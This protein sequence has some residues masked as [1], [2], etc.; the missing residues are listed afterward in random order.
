M[1][2]FTGIFALCAEAQD[3]DVPNDTLP[4]I[5]AETQETPIPIDK[6]LTHKDTLLLLSAPDTLKLKE[7]RDWTTWRPNPKRALWLAIVIPGAGQI[8]NRKYWK[9][10]IVYGGFVGCAYAMRWNNQMYNDY[11]QAYLD[12]MDDDPNTQ[13]YNQFLH[14]GAE[15]D[16]TNKTRYQELFKKRKDRFRRWRDLSFFALVGVYALSVID[17]YVDASLSE[18]DISDNLSL[19]VEPTIINNETEKNRFRSNSLGVS[20]SLNF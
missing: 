9:L 10:P 7:K 1:A 18:F 8:Y 15:I 19:R 14:L 2:L 6:A 12:I 11:S 5:A 4:P 16:D 13:S 20:C 17:A 3:T